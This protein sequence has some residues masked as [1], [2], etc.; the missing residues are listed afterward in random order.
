MHSSRNERM[1]MPVFAFPQCLNFC[2]KDRS[3]HKQI[4]SVYNPSESTVRYEI[5]CTSPQKYTVTEPE[6]TI[7]AQSVINLIVHHTSPT[8]SNC[9]I[10]DRFRVVI[11]DYNT[12]REIGKTSIK[13][14]LSL[15]DNGSGEGD[16]YMRFPERPVAN[17]QKS[18][19]KTNQLQFIQLIIG[20]ICCVGLFWPVSGD[21]AYANS[22][23]PEY[24]QIHITTKLV[25]SF[26]LGFLTC[27]VSIHN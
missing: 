6:G 8:L 11:Q 25:M 4:L 19:P 16:N 2:I 12:K 20:V 15:E 14:R 27:Y 23:I 10:I 13:A 3:K 24:L 7:N 26:I 18:I 17:V 9:D 21:P 1:E 5:H 22:I